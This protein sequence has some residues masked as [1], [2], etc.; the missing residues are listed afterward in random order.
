MIQVTEAAA[1]KVKDHLTREKENLPRGGLRLYAQAGGC[2]G[3]RY[4][5]ALDEPQDGDHVFSTG[6]IQVIVDPT[7]LQ[8]L[9]GA[10]V[11]YQNGDEG[12]G[13]A[14]RNPNAA[15]PCSCGE[16]DSG[17]SCT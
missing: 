2:S 12:E 3:W 15:P 10:T 13:F 4:G 16:P 17:C 6:G 1:E 5:L 8:H 7:S 14:I 9:D 11:D